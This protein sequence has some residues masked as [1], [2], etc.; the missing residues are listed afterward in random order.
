MA[1]LKLDLVNKLKNE[2]YYDEIELIRLAGDPNMNYKFKM[3]D[4]SAKLMNIALV[5]A[6][7]GLVEQYF[8]EQAP[9]SGAVAPAQADVPV[10]EQAPTAK[11]EGQ[12]HT[13][14]S[15]GE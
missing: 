2:K 4:M 12:V 14:Q 3:E 5:N 13:G 6:Q 11:P 15:H 10:Q 1:N 7:L 8:Q 9:Q